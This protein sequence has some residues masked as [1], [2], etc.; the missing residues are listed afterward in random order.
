[1]C[2][3]VKKGGLDMYEIALNGELIDIVKM[4][5]TY[6]VHNLMQDDLVEAVLYGSCARGDYT[7]DSDIDIALLTKSDRLEAKKY[8]EQ[9]ARIATELA[10]KYFAIV[11]FVCLPYEEFL[12]KKTWYPYFMNIATEGEVLYG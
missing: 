6:L 10:M 8:D 1:M 7:E 3:F 2:R 5:S 9:L 12:E 11:N 4:E